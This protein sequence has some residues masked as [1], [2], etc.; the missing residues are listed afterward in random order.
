MSNDVPNNTCDL[1]Q[2]FVLVYIYGEFKNVMELEWIRFSSTKCMIMNLQ[3]QQGFLLY[4]TF[5]CNQMREKNR[6]K[7]QSKDG[8]DLPDGEKCSSG[9]QERIRGY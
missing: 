1:I 7:G 9:N 8:S 2:Y 6:C 4:T 5:R 3:N